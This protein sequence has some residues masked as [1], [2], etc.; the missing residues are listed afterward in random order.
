MIQ[1]FRNDQITLLWHIDFWLEEAY[2]AARILQLHSFVHL[3]LLARYFRRLNVIW[4][5]FFMLYIEVRHEIFGLS[6]LSLW[7]SSLHFTYV[8]N[9]FF[10]SNYHTNAF[11]VFICFVVS[12]LTK[13]KWQCILK[14]ASETCTFWLCVRV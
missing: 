8:A 2:Y 9:R 3:L 7:L 14:R 12:A 13:K 11:V 1:H 10:T 4:N 5:K 6:S